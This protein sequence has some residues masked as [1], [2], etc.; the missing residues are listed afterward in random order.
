MR[1]S[2]DDM[3]KLVDQLKD[4]PFLIKRKPIKRD[5]LIAIVLSLVLSL[6]F[7][8]CFLWGLN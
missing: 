5:V 7:V 4:S 8:I 6:M 3:K 1:M 2:D